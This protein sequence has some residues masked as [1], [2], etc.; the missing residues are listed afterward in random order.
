MADDEREYQPSLADRI[1]N[2]IPSELTATPHVAAGAARR[3]KIAA[4]VMPVVT[5]ELD[6]VRAEVAEGIAQAI[7]AYAEE[8]LDGLHPYEHPNMGAVNAINRCAAIA[9]G[10]TSPAGPG[11]D[12]DGSAPAH[13]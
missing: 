10:Y 11:Q 1:A 9:R 6:K 12:R 3:A 2:A 4:V 13:D 8:A 7:E 5:A